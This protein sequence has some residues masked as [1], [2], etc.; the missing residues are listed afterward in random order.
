MILII[1][2]ILLIAVAIYAEIL[3]IRFAKNG[4]QTK[5]KVIKS[6]KIKRDTSK[7]N[8]IANGYNTTFEFNINGENKTETIFTEK[9]FKEGSIKNCVYLQGKKG[10]M[11]SVAGE[12]FYLANGG[13]IFLI[14]FGL[15]FIFGGLAFNNIITT[16]TIY[17][18]AIGF[19][20]T[21]LLAIFIM[22]LLPKKLKKNKK[23]K[24]SIKEIISTNEESEYSN[25]DSHLVRYIPVIE[26][27]KN[28]I[29]DEIMHY[30]FILI[31][32]FIGTVVLMLGAK[33]A[34]NSYNI[35]NTYSC[36]EAEIIEIYNY[37][38]KSADSDDE[39]DITSVGYIYSYEVNGKK[40]EFNDEVGASKIFNHKH[41]GDTNKLYYNQNNPNDAVPKEKLNNY[42]IMLIIGLL[43]LYIAILVHINTSK[44]IKLYKEYVKRSGGK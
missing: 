20:A 7:G 21:V 13:A 8:R 12:G 42:A 35:K 19:F 17:I 25:V 2:G 10:N 41:V 28:K 24:P 39:N 43:F 29:I 27:S 40:Y 11:L 44:N 18:I 38:A 32:V 4:I 6:E 37:K 22:S 33:E 5:A 34:R 9:K 23:H 36:V 15:V 16:K 26:Q 14:L 3:K 1:I 31:F 30:I